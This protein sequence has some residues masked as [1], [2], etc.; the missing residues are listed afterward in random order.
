LKQFCS[1]TQFVFL[2]AHNRGCIALKRKSGGSSTPWHPSHIRTPPEQPQGYPEHRVN[3]LVWRSWTRWYK[4]R[5][6]RSISCPVS[7]RSWRGRWRIPIGW[8]IRRSVVGTAPANPRGCALVPRPPAAI[9]RGVY[10]NEL[11]A[12]RNSSAP[13]ALLARLAAGTRSLRPPPHSR[14]PAADPTVSGAGQSSRAEP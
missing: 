10:C 7:C 13:A 2:P 5:V 6:V 3:A 12:L 11:R 14:I 4:V 9:V 8:S 1:Q